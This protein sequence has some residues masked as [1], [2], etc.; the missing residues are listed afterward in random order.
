MAIG[1]SPQHLFVHF[2]DQRWK[3]EHAHAREL[4][5]LGVLRE[6]VSSHRAVLEALAALS[7]ADLDRAGRHPRGVPYTVREVFLRYPVHDQNHA[8]QIDGIRARL[9]V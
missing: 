1:A 6:I 3:R 5:L 7:P 4:P 2:D 9:D 8:A